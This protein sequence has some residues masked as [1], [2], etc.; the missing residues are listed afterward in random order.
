MIRFLGED[1]WDELSRLCN[2]RGPKHVAVAYYSSDSHFR[3]GR[4]DTLIV[5]ASEKAIQTRQTSAMVLRAAERRGSRVF[6]HSKLH[7]KIVR[8]EDYAFVGSSNFS[9]NA[10]S[11]REAGLLVTDEAVLGEVD[12]YLQLLERE[13]RR[14][15]KTDIDAL[16]A[17]P[18]ALVLRPGG[19]AVKP[20]LL[21]AVESDLPSLDDVSLSWYTPDVD[22]SHREVK[23][24]ANRLRIPLPRKNEWTWFESPNS[25][26]ALNRTRRLYQGRPMVTWPVKVDSD[27]LIAEFKPH[28]SIASPF[29]GAFQFRNRVIS[30]VGVKAFRTPFDLKR[31]RVRLAAVLSVGLRRA[32]AGLRR[33]VN[34]DVAIITRKQFVEL[35]R[36]GQRGE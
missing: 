6:S 1:L 30:L 3:C 25:R 20:S 26:D 31:D 33:A 27:D 18:L 19:G 14:L 34:D 10:R 2:E 7:A 8:V 12:R 29:L 9:T 24:E 23:G 11:L 5:D 21:E 32:P 15:L 17:I 16:C 28:D 35:Y 13:S 36:L 4:G 22:L